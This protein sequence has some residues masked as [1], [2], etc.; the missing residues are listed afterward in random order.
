MVLAADNFETDHRWSSVELPHITVMIKRQKHEEINSYQWWYCKQFNGIST[1]K[2]SEQQLYLMF[3]TCDGFNKNSASSNI[4]G[5]IWLNNTQIFSGLLMQLSELIELPANLLHSE[6]PEENKCNNILTICCSNS[7][8]SLHARL[9]LRGKIIYAT[10]QVS[11]NEEI[12]DKHKNSEKIENNVLDYTVSID[13][14]CE[15]IGVVFNSKKKYKA[16]LKPS[17]SSTQLFGSDSDENKELKDDLFI[18]RLAI[19]ILVVGT[20]GD[21]QPFIA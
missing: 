11:V 10:G 3:E 13:N 19:V 20:R 15:R 1:D 9:I 14:D 2:R 7:S 12:I 6:N 16:P 17:S 21:V 18:P 4:T 5:T 8:L